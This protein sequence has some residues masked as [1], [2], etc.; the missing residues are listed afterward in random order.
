[1]PTFRY[2]YYDS[3]G[4]E[5]QGMLEAEAL[6]EALAVLR[7]R[8]IY[9]TRVE[10][11]AKRQNKPLPPG[12]LGAFF[13]QFSALLRTGKITP[14]EALRLLEE[15]IPQRSLAQ[16]RIAQ[17]LV[18]R[19]DSFHRAMAATGL[20]PNIA[21]AMVE[22]GERS[23]KLEEA[24]KL[25]Y[26][27]FIRSAA[28]NRKLR[29][30]LTYPAVVLALAV[31][32]TYG[33]MVFIVPQFVG[34]LKELDRELPLLTQV[35]VFLS[36]A[37]SSPLGIALM[38]L[39]VAGGI[40]GYRQAMSQS[41]SRKRV[42]RFFLRLP[43]VGVLFKYSNLTNIAQTLQL[44]Y[45]AGI[46]LHESL[47]QIRK[48]LSSALYREALA[49]IRKEI[50]SGKSLFSLFGRD[51]TLF[52]GLFVNLVRIGEESG[53]LGGMLEHASTQYSAE[54]EAILDG[55][56]SLLEP[57]L[58]IVVGGMVGVVMLA[59]LLPYFSIAQGLGG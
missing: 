59:V 18:V 35:I 30:A 34:I 1:M 57:L 53:D 7:A 51:T 46:P 43:V 24:L 13:R 3:T 58:L 17:Q 41:E 54:A 10:E 21:I 45:E 31:L 56:S 47:D 29:G 14:A 33:L 11:Q 38:I 5:Q 26:E 22:A 42:E 36:N 49:E 55:L 28:F 39:V 16:Y 12:V 27:Y 25:L 52:P 50:T 48:V 44:L 23:G 4:A 37:L 8:H 2:F 32:M 9:P 6:G 19:G 40:Y 15:I 20:F